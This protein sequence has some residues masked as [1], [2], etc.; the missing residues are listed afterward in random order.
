MNMILSSSKSWSSGHFINVTEHV[1]IYDVSLALAETEK[2]LRQ[3]CCYSFI[4]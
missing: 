4:F 2:A 1:Q 3:I